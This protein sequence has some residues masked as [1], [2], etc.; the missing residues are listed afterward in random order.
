[1]FLNEL[2]FEYFEKKY[3]YFSDLVE[4]SKLSKCVSQPF[5]L[6]IDSESC[7]S[8]LTGGC[9]P[10]WQS[11][12]QWKHLSTFYSDLK[13][14]CAHSSI[15]I[16]IFFNGAPENFDFWKM[17]QLETKKKVDRIFNSDGSPRMINWIEPVF[18]KQVIISEITQDILQDLNSRKIFCYATLDDHKKEM[19]QYLKENKCDALL[20]AD[21]ELIT[22]IYKYKEYNKNLSGL[23]FY[24]AEKFKLTTK[25]EITSYNYDLATTLE[26][27]HLNPQKM[28]F[29]S[30]LISLGQYNFAS[31]KKNLKNFSKFEAKVIV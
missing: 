28:I 25:K 8:R 7:M 18:S 13:T 24:S 21:F 27:F 3:L 6:V 22:L 29:L 11:G 1:M 10:D 23:K 14:A 26:F 15:E 17:K 16:I 2:V 4:F 9:F 19:V 20:T 30:I 31:L 5:R 12:G